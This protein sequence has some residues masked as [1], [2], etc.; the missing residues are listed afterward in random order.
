M[1]HVPPS[2]TTL[3]LPRQIAIDGPAASGKSS[4]GRALAARFGYLFLDT[5]L[6]Y[7]AFTLAALRAGVPPSDPAECARVA[8]SFDLRVEAAA[9]TRIFVGGEDITPLL[10]TPEVEANV[11]AY[12]AIPAV[13]TQ[14]VRIQ[15]K[16]ARR[17]PAV[18]AGRDIGTVVLPRAP[19]KFFLEASEDARALR[20]RA[21]ASSWGTSQGLD[22][23]HRD[24][25]G[26]DVTDSTRAASPLQPAKD[27]IVIDTTKMALAEVI[28]FATEK[29]LC[30]AG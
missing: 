28:A 1:R 15:R 16:V 6:M 24:I 2:F 7:R 13:R 20:R 14:M 5:G 25:S 11:S 4:L 3:D 27:A 22:E 30:A 17:R 19:L 9:D 21:Q 18:L 23:A 10:R 12:S 8:A 29:V 26:R